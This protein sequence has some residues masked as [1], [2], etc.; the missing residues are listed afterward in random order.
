MIR[1]SS[2]T[3]RL[4]ATFV[5]FALLLLTGVGIF[6]YLNGRS[7]LRANTKSELVSIAI[8]KQSALKVWSEERLQ[9][10]VQLA[11]TRN[12]RIMRPRC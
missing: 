7:A 2:M 10:I 3:A 5:L 4:S 11:D 12:L 6:S 1:W 8:E 9:D